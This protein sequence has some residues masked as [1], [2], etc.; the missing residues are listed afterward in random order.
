MAYINVLTGLLQGISE[1]G[2]IPISRVT[3]LIDALAG[4]QPNVGP[5][6]LEIED[7]S[8]LQVALDAKQDEIT[9]AN[10]LDASLVGDG[11]IS[12]TV[13]N[14]LAG[15]TSGVQAQLNALSAGKQPL[16]DAGARLDASL[17]ATGAV[18]NTTFNYLSGATS[19]VQTQFDRLLLVAGRLVGTTPAS[20]VNQRGTITMSATRAGLGE[21]D[22]LF[23]AAQPNAD[24]IVMLTPIAQDSGDNLFTAAVSQVTVSTTGFRIRIARGG[25]SLD[26]DAYFW[27]IPL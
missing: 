27:V 7:T 10:R 14:F 6:D 5:G 11:S 21:F 25:T 26:R 19:P 1:A 15:V 9:A 22:M 8:G 2:P 16:I 12:T 18:T 13:F 3:G 23:S 4:K 24:Y 17:V 20:V